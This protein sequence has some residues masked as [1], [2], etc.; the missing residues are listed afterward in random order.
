M[1]TSIQIAKTEMLIRQP[2]VAVFQAFIDPAITTQFWFT[3]SSGKV[4]PNAQLTWTW[5][6]YALDVPVRV[7]E[8]QPHSKIEIEWGDGPHKSTVRWDFKVLGSALTYVTIS[9]YDFQGSDEEVTAKVIDS[10]GGFTMVM[11][12]LKAWLEHGIV[13]NLIGDKFPE[14][15]RN[16]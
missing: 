8:V 3:K 12:G 10:T 1:P 9:N 13:L 7:I 2:V 5:E 14:E 4:V 15:L 6:M 11:A 16:S